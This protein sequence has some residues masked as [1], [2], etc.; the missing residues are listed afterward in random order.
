MP[1]P[2]IHTAR[3]VPPAPATPRAP[4][5]SPVAS[6]ARAAPLEHGPVSDLPVGAALR[7]DVPTGEAIW[8]HG[9]PH[10]GEDLGLTPTAPDL[11]AYLGPLFLDS[12]LVA[13][14]YASG[15]GEAVTPGRGRPSD[16]GRLVSARLRIARPMVYDSEFALVAHALA[17]AQAGGLFG[18]VRTVAGAAAPTLDPAEA[19]AVAE[20]WLPTQKRQVARALVRALR[21][22]GYDGLCYGY[23][24]RHTNG[25]RAVIPFAWPQLEVLA[26]QRIPALVAQ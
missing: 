7:A 8:H 17:V 14:A 6:P 12:P 22:D 10:A 5:A 20:G 3:P 18:P 25:S 19:A 9:T 11:S 15:G 13:H 4:V 26:D 2:N 24:L 1:S 21:A 23:G 16:E